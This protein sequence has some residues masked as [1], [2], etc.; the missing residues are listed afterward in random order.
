[1]KAHAQRCDQAVRDHGF[2][3]KEQIG[4]PEGEDEVTVSSSHIAVFQLYFYFSRCFFLGKKA[5][6]RFF[7]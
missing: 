7:R 3:S 4:A 2:R 5:T 6:Q 1:M